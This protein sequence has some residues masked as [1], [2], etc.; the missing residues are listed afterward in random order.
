MG[1]GLSSVAGKCA[2]PAWV[3]PPRSWQ[4]ALPAGSRRFTDVPR[5]GRHRDSPRAGAGGWRIPQTAREPPHLPV[6]CAPALEQS[7]MATWTESA[8]GR[9]A[10]GEANPSPADPCTR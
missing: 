8:L 5:P 3:A 1:S 2:H 9:A 6:A 4:G 10:G 7:P